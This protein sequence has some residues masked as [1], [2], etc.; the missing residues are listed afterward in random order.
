M[1]N[2]Q[3]AQTK[4]RNKKITLRSF[5]IKNQVILFIKNL[6][7]AKFKKK[8]FYKFIKLFEIEDIVDLQ[9]Y[10]FRLLKY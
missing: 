5:K 10:C 6:K 8:L 2:A 1:Q 4:V 7:D 9:A 3:F